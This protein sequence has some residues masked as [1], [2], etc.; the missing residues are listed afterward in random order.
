LIPGLLAETAGVLARGGGMVIGY[1]PFENAPSESHY[2]CELLVKVL[3]CPGGL[4]RL[5]V[6]MRDTGGYSSS[7]ALSNR[8]TPAAASDP[9]P[10]RDG[11]MLV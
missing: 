5:A 1:S 3:P 10:K 4:G 8:S 9:S 11:A 7:P 2:P 6:D